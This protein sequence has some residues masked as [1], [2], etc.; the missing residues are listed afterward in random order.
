[1]KKEGEDKTRLLLE[2]AIEAEFTRLE[3]CDNPDEDAEPIMNRLYTLYNLKN[4]ENKCINSANEQHAKEKQAS[5]ELALKRTQIREQKLDRWIAMGVQ[6]GLALIGILAYDG[7][8]RRGL[9]FE[10]TGSVTSPMTRNLI[11]KMLP[12][13]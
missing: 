13:K 6:I 4:E 8:Y 1:M 11:S 9:K 5:E 3:S 2:N 7:W 12:K 10:E